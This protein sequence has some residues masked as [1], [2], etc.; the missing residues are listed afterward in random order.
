MNKYTVILVRQEYDVIESSTFMHV[1]APSL[2]D[3]W[4]QAADGCRCT[5]LDVVAVIPGH[6][7]VLTK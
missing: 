6:V 1:E 4:D 5:L 3:A 2:Q 7:E